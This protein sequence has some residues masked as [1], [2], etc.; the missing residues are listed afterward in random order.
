MAEAAVTADGA[1]DGDRV[2]AVAEEREHLQFLSMFFYAVGALAAMLALVPALA[3]FV[4]A[5]LRQPGEPLAIALAER[6]GLA[7]AAVLAGA[8]LC[9]G[10][11]LFALMA[12]AGFL[13]ARCRSYRF[14]L[15]VA[16]AA[17]LFVPI[18]TVLGA[19]TAAIL[20]RPATERL[21][22]NGEPGD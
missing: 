10:F 4:A 5:S 3:L 15:A 12:R 21:F 11:L 7:T 13:L 22:A 2:P 1:A 18:G 14:C 20:K 9:A 16:W 17:C 8:L 6:L 19:V